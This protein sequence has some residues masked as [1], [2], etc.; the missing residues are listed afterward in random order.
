[1]REW[2]YGLLGLD[3]VK[4]QPVRYRRTAPAGAYRAAH[5]GQ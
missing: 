5:A 4:E 3:A 1:M 2:V